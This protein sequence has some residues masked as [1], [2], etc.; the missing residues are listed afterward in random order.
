MTYKLCPGVVAATICEEHFLIASGEARGK[1]PYIEGITRPGLYF[2]KL[3]EKN[4]S[5]EEIISC[6]AEDYSVSTDKADSAFRNFAKS[7]VNK[8]YMTFYED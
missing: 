4:I 7:L 3:L 2:W 8:G 6:A 1:V 5:V